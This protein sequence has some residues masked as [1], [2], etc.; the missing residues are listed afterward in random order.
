ML[1]V[2]D[3]TT[4]DAFSL[5]GHLSQ[6]FPTPLI[7]SSNNSL[8]VY[9]WFSGPRTDLGL[10]M[11]IRPGLMPVEQTPR[12][13]FDRSLANGAIR[14]GVVCHLTLGGV[15][16]APVLWPSPSVAG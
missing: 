5:S 7:R 15:Q 16:A 14:L 13:R 1:P 3:V 6:R 11:S 4:R 8:F 2:L 12:I 10:P 9:R